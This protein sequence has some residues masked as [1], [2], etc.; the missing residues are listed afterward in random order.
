MTRLL[1]PL[2]LFFTALVF[3]QTQL[4]VFNKTTK[5]PIY[6]AAVYCDDEL[7]GKTDLNGTLSFKTKC[8]KV[9]ILASNFEDVLAEVRNTMEVA[10]QPLA[11]KRGNIDRVIINDKSDPRAL[12]ILDELNKRAKENSPKS[13]DSY[14]FKS[15]T[16]FSL[17]LDKDS[18]DIYKNFLAARKDSI[19]KV[20]QNGFKQKEKEKKAESNGNN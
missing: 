6:S 15:Y 7:L 2:F 16:K 1:F 14:N 10:M 3:G 9:E 17:D 19:S 12:K 4:K 8:K 18:I 11:E 5:Q 20:D 13:L